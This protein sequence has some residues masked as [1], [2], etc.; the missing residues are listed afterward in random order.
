[1][2]NKKEYLNSYRQQ[3]HV[4]RNLK[5]LYFE[6]PS[7]REVLQSQIE[8]CETLRTQIAEKIL[9][10]KDPRYKVLLYEKYMNG[11]TLEEIAGILNYSKRHVERLHVAALKSV[12][13]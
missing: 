5:R 2:K 9:Q 4:I 1:M 13:L 6:N 3:E 11:H 7:Q 12:K 10:I 8:N